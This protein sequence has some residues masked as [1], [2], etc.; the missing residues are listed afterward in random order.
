MGSRWWGQ[1]VS[2]ECHVQFQIRH[3]LLLDPVELVAKALAV[4]CWKLSG[5]GLLMLRGLF[6]SCKLP[7]ETIACISLCLFMMIILQVQRQYL[8]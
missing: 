5:T 7:T 3:E 8:L 4:W 6:M 1:E 2:T